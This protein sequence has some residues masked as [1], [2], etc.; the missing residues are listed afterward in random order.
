MQVI[1]G[2]YSK[3]I[4]LERTLSHLISSADMNTDTAL[5]RK[6]KGHFSDPLMLLLILRC[7]YMEPESVGTFFSFIG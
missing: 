6:E 3:V 5:I 7:K 2:N 1:I 4:T